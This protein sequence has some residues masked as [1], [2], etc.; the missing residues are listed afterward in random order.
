MGEEDRCTLFPERA[1]VLSLLVSC[2]RQTVGDR[3]SA[4]GSRME[5]IGSFQRPN[6]E[7]VLVHRS[8]G[9]NI[10]R[11]NR[12]AADDDFDLV[13]TL[14]PLTS[15]ALKAERWEEERGIGEE[16]EEHSAA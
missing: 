16:L 3:R 8:R 2:R 4:C 13:L 6:G 14:P 7:F 15:R 10:E 9:S 12:I 1:T 5:P 11:F